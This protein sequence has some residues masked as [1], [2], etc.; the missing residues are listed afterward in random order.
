VA[1]HD[2]DIANQAGAAFRADL[3]NVVAALFSN[4]S[5][6]SAPAVTFA[7][8]LWKDTANAKLKMR[9]AGNT[10]WIELFSFDETGNTA[11][12]LGTFDISALTAETAPAL[13]DNLPFHDASAGA[14]RRI[15]FQNFFATLNVM[16][17]ISSVALDDKLLAYD[18]SGNAA[19]TLT[20][21]GL[22]AA[23][24]LLTEDATPDA[25]ADFLLS[26]DTSAG[27]VKKVKPENLAGLTGGMTL[28]DSGSVTGGSTKAITD[29]PASYS[30]LILQLR[31]VSCSANR[32]LVLRASVNNGSSYAA[33]G[34][35][36]F[37]WL[38]GSAAMEALTG[39]SFGIGGTIFG[40]NNDSL[41]V[42]LELRQYGG[43]PDCHFTMTVFNSGVLRY[44]SEGAFSNGADNI[45]ALQLSWSGTGNFDAGTFALYG[46]G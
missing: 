26:Y 35:S 38:D 46:A 11:S 45:D 22:F 9:N 31:G 34:Y 4:S 1:Q 15:S 20:P 28:I 3:N 12:T 8:M 23:L 44:R 40:N 29:I 13:A 36:G 7:H 25:A 30:S 33:T 2:G 27:A 16:A 10:G 18:A 17:A 14:P 6:G 42:T 32:D 21:A 37:R 24:N 39:S 5:G 43:G 41:D 19:G